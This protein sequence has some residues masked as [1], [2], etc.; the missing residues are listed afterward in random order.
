[1]EAGVRMTND[2]Q[3]EFS[4]LLRSSRLKLFERLMDAGTALDLHWTVISD[5]ENG[6]KFPGIW[7]LKRLCEGL[8]LDFD[9]T[10]VLWAHAALERKKR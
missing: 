3:R 7:M 5:Y 1:M 8:R 4:T 6:R 9:S 2:S 10:V